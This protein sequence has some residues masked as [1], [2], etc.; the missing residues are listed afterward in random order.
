MKPGLHI[1]M[2]NTGIVANK[3]KVLRRIA[4]YTKLVKM[5][6]TYCRNVENWP[7][8]EKFRKYRNR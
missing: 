8:L 7:F 2:M 3:I 1:N 6:P 5:R 4:G